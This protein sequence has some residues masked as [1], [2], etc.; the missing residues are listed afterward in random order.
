[1]PPCAY[2]AE[3]TLRRRCRACVATVCDPCFAARRPALCPGCGAAHGVPVRST[4]ATHAPRVCEH[5]YEFVDE[6]RWHLDTVA[7]AEGT[8]AKRRA[9]CDLYRCIVV[10]RDHARRHPPLWDKIHEKLLEFMERHDFGHEFYAP[11]FG[12]LCAEEKTMD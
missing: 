3:P 11:L 8:A 7:S 4:R 1:M 10:N 2:C 9:A 12:D 6:M 5:E